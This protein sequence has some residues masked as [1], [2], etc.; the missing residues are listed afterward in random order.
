MTQIAVLNAYFDWLCRRLGDGENPE[1]FSKL[2]RYL[3]STEFTYMIPRDANRAED[4][5]SLRYRFANDTRL[6]EVY[7]DGPCSIL[8]MIVA[9]A[10]RIE[11]TIMDDPEMGDRT[12]QWVWGMIINLGLGSMDNDRFD[13]EYVDHVIQRFLNREYMP[14]GRGGLFTIKR[15]EYDLRDVEIWYQ[16]NWYLN[17]I[18]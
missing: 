5:L 12:S 17:S 8:E 16:T 11:E 3:Y 1:R 15:C 13:E 6:P 18:M 4:G 14:D 2:L 7:L 10:I 9:L